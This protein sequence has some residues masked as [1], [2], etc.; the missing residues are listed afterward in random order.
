MVDSIPR[1]AVII[2]DILEPFATALSGDDAQARAFV[3]ALGWT[4]PTVPPSLKAI[5]QSTRVISEQA[6]TLQIDAQL[7]SAGTGV[8]VDVTRYTKIADAFI[9]LVSALDRLPAEL[10]AQFPPAFVAAT[11]ID[12]QFVRRLLDTS[13]ATALASRNG[14]VESALRI[15]GI[16]EVVDEPS[17]PATFQPA[18]RRRTIHWDRIALLFD[19]VSL[20]K[21]VYGWGGA[22]FDPT[23]TFD[24]IT[25]LSFEL[26]GPADIDWPSPQRIEA[27]TGVR[28]PIDR[29]GA[30]Q[31]LMPLLCA[32][33]D[34]LR[35]TV[36]PLPAHQGRPP[37]VAL[38]VVVT[39]AI[40]DNFRISRSLSL[41]VIA[42]DQFGAGLSIA[43]RPGTAPHA[44]LGV[45]GP[46]TAVSAS[47]IGVAIVVDKSQPLELISLPGVNASAGSI[48]IGAGVQSSAKGVE[49]TYHAAVNRVHLA[50]DLGPRDS[51]LS[52]ILPGKIDDA[53]FDLGFTWSPS[54]L[55][56]D[57]S[58]A[59]DLAIPLHISI[60]PARID[61]LM[62]AATLGAPTS[63][64]EL[65]ISGGGTIGPLRL[66]VDRVGAVINAALGSGN[67]GV[68]DVSLRPKPPTGV[69]IVVDA[70]VVAGGGFLSIDTQKG[71]YAGALELTFAQFLSLKA[72]GIITTRM[73]DGTA[74]FSL[75]V[76]ITAEFGSGIQLGFGFTLLAVGG[77]IGLHRSMR[78]DAI[79]EGVRTGGIESVMFPKDVVANA[80]RILSDL[81]AFFPPRQGTFLIG[82]MAKLGWGTPTLISLS[83]GIIIEIPGN[84][85]IVGVLKVALPAENIAVVRLQ[86]NFVGALEFDRQRAWFFASLYDS[87][88]LF[89]TIDGEMGVLVA[90]GNDANVVIAVG[91]FHPRYTP[92]PLP[93]P[94]PRRISIDVLNT[95]V[96]RIRA[97]GYFATTSNSVQFGAEA[98]A[99]FGFSALN[100]SGHIAFDALIRF[101][102][103]YFI[104]DFSSHFS[105][106]VFG[107]GVWGLRIRLEVEGPTPWRARGSAG[108]SLLLCDIDVDIDVTWGEKR[109]TA[110]PPIHVLPALAAELSK[111]DSWQAVPPPNA[112]LLVTLRTLPAAQSKV[113]LHPLGALQV[114]Q[115]LAPLDS[116]LDRIGAQKPADG[117]RFSLSAAS[118]TF[119]K[120]RDVDAQFA[121]AQYEDLSDADRLSRQAF[122]QRHGGVE[123]SVSGAQMESATAVTRIARYDLI[124]IDTNARRHRRRFFRLASAMFTHWILGSA[125]A[126]SRL[127]L[128]RQ[129][130]RIPVQDGVITKS[131]GFAVTRQD[132]N[133]PFSAAS[134]LF[135]SEGAAR[136]WMAGAVA[137]DRGLAGNLQVVP[138]FE[139][140]S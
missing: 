33:P 60:G 54:G 83:L 129:I 137:A 92:P 4:I 127:S 43:F 109:D 3:S 6:T 100:V 48:E 40:P 75:L 94:N 99:F 42:P 67:L 95:S 32:L 26:A 90:Y 51:F 11:H 58:A 20:I 103:F 86:A 133:R 107:L 124:T 24:S 135:T 45:T 79:A 101:S 138:R 39:G 44:R 97:S 61:Q 52:A 106:K 12:T 122:E 139:A 136:D 55:R 76:I 36:L 89:I 110:L 114:L 132:T 81:R 19:P 77:L 88:V 57:G 112:N 22:G 82:P 46:E 123:M 69:G 38:G 53:V 126:L 108:I 49:P 8:S 63:S 66:S 29:V 70:G 116:K 59:F 119:T 30:R 65:S 23:A 37:G 27:L 96:A 105:V 34:N 31:L 130:A 9:Q 87:R 1:V 25:R 134:A 64:L 121:P 80:P 104:V 71:E 93:F 47:N 56:I 16:I 18:Y 74:G 7:S 131:E 5:A 73:P 85:A 28:P 13:L 117:N 113:V 41:R 120:R 102:P 115:R 98:E 84:V 78:L 17:N 91:G 14:I 15:A 10:A 35:L 72:I 2:A 125:V 68:A 21:Q 62:L 50:V 128:K 118:P 140:A 111:A